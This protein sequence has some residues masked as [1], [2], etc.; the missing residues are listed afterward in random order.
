MKCPYCSSI[1]TKVTDKRESEDNGVT[2]RRRECLKCSKRFTTYERIDSVDL[3]IIKRNNDREQFDRE[4]LRAGIMK[5][6]EKRPI[7]L[8]KIDV[9]ID[10]V[11][12]HLRR[13]ESTEIGSNVIGEIVMDML[14][15]TDEVAYVRFASVYRQFK[16]TK[17]FMDEINNL[18]K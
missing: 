7:N 6:C 9:I 18:Q 17:E 10:Y 5:A 1:E 13:M 11:E 15:K 4:K 2:R 3:I 16:D 12:N 14:K 8:E